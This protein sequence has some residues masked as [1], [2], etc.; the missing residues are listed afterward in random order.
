MR[1]SSGAYRTLS[2]EKT[3]SKTPTT[4]WA[5]QADI[6]LVLMMRHTQKRRAAQPVSGSSAGWPLC[7]LTFECGGGGE[8][9]NKRQS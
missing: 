1:V 9:S 5:I 7:F 3:I 8:M 6:H 2:L 4:H